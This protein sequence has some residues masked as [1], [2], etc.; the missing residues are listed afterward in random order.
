MGK[1]DKGTRP[2]VNLI[3]PV[4]KGQIPFLSC[5]KGHS[6]YRWQLSNKK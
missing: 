6:A 1:I 3:G 4:D 2:V 5:D